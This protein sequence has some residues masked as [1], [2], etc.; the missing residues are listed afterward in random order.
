MASARAKKKT[1]PGF[2]QKLNKLE[3][4]VERMEDGSLSLEDSLKAFEEGME[5][6]RQC[7]E[8]LDKSR[9]RV[10]VLLKR[11]EKLI[12][13]TLPTDDGETEEE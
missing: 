7:V 2:E 6:Y 12:T 8:V 11:G 9:N 4:I 13:E 5:L 10:E 3:Q 1:E